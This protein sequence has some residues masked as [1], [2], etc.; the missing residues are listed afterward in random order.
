MGSYGV[1]VEKEVAFRGGPERFT[2]VWHYRITAPVTADYQA[3]ADAV[4]AGERAFFP[5]DATF[6]SVR[7]F[8]PTDGNPND[9]LIRLVQDLTGA[10][11]GSR[12]GSVVYPELCYCVS[13]PAGRSET[14]QRRIY[15]RKYL[16]ILRFHGSSDSSTTMLLT[17]ST[18]DSVKAF[19]EGMES[20]G[21]GPIQYQMVTPRDQPVSD[22][23]ATVLAYA[24]VRQ[25]KQ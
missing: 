24:R 10:G 5:S 12:A 22:P 19:Y 3:L 15:V 4:V 9:N 16:R 23:S 13:M 8:G 6:K 14:S 1:T 2:N 17:T 18:K 25:M 21:L 7:V 20:V 11:T